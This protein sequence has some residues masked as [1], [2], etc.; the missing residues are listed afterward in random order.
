MAL[1]DPTKADYLAVVDAWSSYGGGGVPLGHAFPLYS[2]TRNEPVLDV[3]EEFPDTGYIFL[4]NRGTLNTWDFVR[5]RPEK[6][7]QH[8]DGKARYVVGPTPAALDEQLPNCLCATLTDVPDF[9]PVTSPS[10]LKNPTQN[11]SPIFFIHS[12]RKFYGPLRRLQVSRTGY[13][14]LEAIQWVPHDP[15][16]LVHEFSLEDL[17]KAGVRQVQ[18]SHPDG[19]RNEV[20]TQPIKML[21]G[22]VLS[23]TSPRAFDRLPDAQLIDWYL[24]WRDLPPIPEGLLRSLQ[25]ASD[26]LSDTTSDAIQRRC[27][28]VTRLFSTME[29]LQGERAAVARRYLESEEGQKTLKQQLDKEVE[30]RVP[31]LEREV[32]RKRGELAAEKQNLAEQLHDIEAERRRRE[33]TLQQGLA[34]LTQQRADLEKAVATMQDQLQADAA[35]LAAKLEKQA[36]LLAIIGAGARTV[37]VAA[38]A[39]VSET[40]NGRPTPE[41][42]FWGKVELPRPTKE[43]EDLKEETALLNCLEEELGG[44]PLGFHRDFLANLWITLKSSALNLIM[45]PPGY[46]KSSVVSALARALGHGNALLEIAVRRS[47]SDDR[48]LL[49]FYDTFH[50]RYDPGPT[51][52]ATRLLQAQEDWDGAKRGL[53]FILLDE[54]NLAAPEYYFSELLQIATRPPEQERRLRLFDAAGLPAAAAAQPHQ[55]RLNPNVSFWGTINYDETTERLSPRLLDRTGMIFLTARD[56]LP[57]GAPT[58]RPLVTK[59]VKAGQVVQAF[60]RR[61]TECPTEH[62][63]LLAPLLDFLK[64]P[65]EEHGPGIDLS[66]RV[67][68][69]VKRYLANAGKLL[70]PA[71]AVDFVFQ[72]RVLPVLRGRGTPYAARIKALAD[73]LTEAGLERSARHVRETL[74]LA[75]VN[76]GDIDFLAYQ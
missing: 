37:R 54:F 69:A 9:D 52:L 1:I 64:Q 70:S 11:V 48:Y 3:M 62:W 56:V 66:P 26:H 29:V 73:R 49:G 40:E 36:P 67:R 17:G 68:E 41:Q 16:N 4:L 12:G 38:A 18:F 14:R 74:A 10:V 22:P 5:V 8:T 72:Q 24:R 75:E 27:Q 76:F 57:V 6:N 20:T 63:D 45:G 13:D 33:E 15:D 31:E 21:V 32:A 23:V 2:L 34:E 55:V 65:S 44:D 50:G 30:R 47:W 46:G 58:A 28:R 35:K 53:Y 25:S 42:H 51:G 43:L 59:G 39:T 19:D 61:P 60:V 7:R 71:R